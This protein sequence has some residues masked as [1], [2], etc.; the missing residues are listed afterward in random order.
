M[1]KSRKVWMQVP[2]Q[3]PKTAVPDTT[4]RRLQEQA[5]DLVARVLKPK[6]ISPPPAESTVNYLI[7]IYTK[8][9]R[10]YFYFCAT[11]ACP[12]PH[13]LAPTFDIKFARMEYVGNDQFNL[14][15]M[16][17]TQ[18]WLELYPGQ[19]QDECLQLIA[20]DPFFLP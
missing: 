15:C 2:T 8:W 4:K 17:H 13:A 12:D 18:E 3:K 11:Y 5:D 1:A 19:T 10:R 14:A 20:E 7:D 16:R 9:F 6:H